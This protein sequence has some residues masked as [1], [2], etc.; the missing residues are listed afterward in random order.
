ME[1]GT[2][3]RA[4]YLKP[5]FFT[6]ERIG[7]LDPL[8]RLAWQGLWCQA[9][10]DGRLKDRPKSLKIEILPYDDVD[11]DALLNTLQASGFIIRY[12]AQGE[13]YIAIPSFLEH[14]KPHPKEAS[15]AYPA[16][17]KRPP[18]PVPEA[19]MNH[20]S[21]MHDPSM[22]ELSGNHPGKLPVNRMIIK[23]ESESARG[24]DGDTT[25]PPAVT[26]IRDLVLS[27]L[28]G[29]FQRDPVTFDEAEQLGRDFAGEHLRVAEAI[30]TC[31]RTSEAL[32]GGI[33]FP[34]RVRRFLEPPPT[35]AQPERPKQ[36]LP[37]IFDTPEDYAAT[38]RPVRERTD[39]EYAQMQRD[40]Y[41]RATGQL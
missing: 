2:V 3:S 22:E 18:K 15:A 25:P 37:P 31:R 40:E 8:A 34:Q 13:R 19:S 35:P 28:S 23:S 41:L 26:E 33:P 29:K 12:E 38:I 16:P 24:R 21:V 9:D 6:N 14:Q 7:D 36:D 39:E 30:E 11:F 32:G 17:P 27:K 20:A 10:R 5:T 4:R 1:E